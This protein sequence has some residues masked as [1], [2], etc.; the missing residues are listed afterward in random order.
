[1]F[2]KIIH[3]S[4]VFAQ[5]CVMNIK[6]V[7][8]YRKSF[9]ISFAA[10]IVWMTT[11][12]LLI[13]VIYVHTDEIAGWEKG[14]ILIILSFYYFITGVANFFFRENFEEFGDKMRRGLLDQFL[15]KPAM[16]QIQCFFGKMRFDQ[17]ASPIMTVF[18]FWYGIS[19]MT[20]P[21]AVSNVI[22]GLFYSLISVAFFY[23][24]L[25]LV[26]TST[27]YLEKANT[28][29][30]VMWNL[31]QVGRYPRQIFTGFAKIFFQFIFPMA[32]MTSIPSEMFIGFD[33]AGMQL[34]FFAI[35]L[36]FCILS[37]LFF[38]MGIKKYASAN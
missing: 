27:F 29:G 33:S 22:I 16:F 12:T 23:H 21:L 34:L 30:S 4:K 3:N 1:M 7:L 5:I 13:E 2:K 19:Q 26:A 35:T 31:S 10:I 17:V 8:M 25:L 14:E 38:H 9:Y 37:Q 24:F 20:A 11:Y 32:L 18:L 28:L 6:M 15:T 36:G